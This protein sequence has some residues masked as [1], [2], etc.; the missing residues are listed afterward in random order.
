LAK[1]YEV[2]YARLAMRSN[3][4]EYSTDSVFKE[5]PHI[6]GVVKGMVEEMA[7]FGH[8]TLP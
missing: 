8:L 7:I 4:L 3:Q 1:L 5:L 6:K 2:E